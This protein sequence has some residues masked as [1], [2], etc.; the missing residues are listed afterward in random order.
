MNDTSGL[1]RPKLPRKRVALRTHVAW[2]V[3]TIYEVNDTG[4]VT[5]TIDGFD[6]FR[7][8]VSESLTSAKNLASMLLQSR[9]HNCEDLACPDWSID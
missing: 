3:V 8:Y 6:P 5:Y 2:K 4:R 1:D 9:G 7:S